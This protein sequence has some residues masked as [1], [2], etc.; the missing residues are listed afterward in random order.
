M[1]L[2]CFHD[3]YE[4]TLCFYEA[5]VVRCLTVIVL[6]VYFHHGLVRRLQELLAV[7]EDLRSRPMGTQYKV[8]WRTLPIDLYEHH[9]IFIRTFK[10]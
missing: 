9:D 5:I 8:Y 4:S 2:W 10:A 7:K 3:E 6:V 1:F